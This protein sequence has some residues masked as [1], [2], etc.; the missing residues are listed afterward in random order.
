[1][2][3][4]PCERTLKW[5]QFRFQPIYPLSFRTEND[6]DPISTRTS[7]ELTFSPLTTVTEPGKL[8]INVTCN[9]LVFD[10]QS[11]YAIHQLVHNGKPA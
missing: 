8:V 11:I 10:Y 3:R 1:M 4:D 2:A 5:R 7:L 6:M 9:V